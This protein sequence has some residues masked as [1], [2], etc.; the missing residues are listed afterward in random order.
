M[1]WLKWR[2]VDDNDCRR[3]RQRQPASVE[4]QVASA[5]PR[6]RFR[7]NVLRHTADFRA[8][9][10]SNGMHR[11]QLVRSSVFTALLRRRR[12]RSRDFRPGVPTRTLASNAPQHALR[13]GWDCDAQNAH[14]N[15]VRA[16]LWCA[17]NSREDEHILIFSYYE[18]YEINLFSPIVPPYFCLVIERRVLLLLRLILL[19]IQINVNNY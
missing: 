14:R 5:L 13:F 18:N 12:Q 10:Y 15:N 19:E 2:F 17:D 11:E 8:V 16:E 9:S 3:R 7:V 1:C 6:A 4:S